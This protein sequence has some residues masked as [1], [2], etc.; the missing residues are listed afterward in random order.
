MGNFFVYIVTNF[1][2]TTLYIGVTNH[3]KRRISEHYNDSM[4][5]KVSFA[6]KYNCYHLIYFET[7]QKINEAI[8]R[9]KV[10]KKWSRKKKEDLINSKNPN[11][12]FLEVNSL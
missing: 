2:K 4:K 7:F 6:G 12:E 10:L 9:E 5:S 3:L 11:W 1:N 8:R